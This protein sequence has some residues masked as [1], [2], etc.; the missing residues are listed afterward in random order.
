MAV[1]KLGRFEKLMNNAPIPHHFPEI[2][3]FLAI[4]SSPVCRATP[5]LYPTI[6]LRLTSSLHCGCLSPPD[7]VKKRKEKE[8][9]G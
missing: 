7:P 6:Y 1:V 2:D 9:L 4:F 3:S 5:P 8:S